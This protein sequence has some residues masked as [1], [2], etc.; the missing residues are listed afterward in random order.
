M[1]YPGEGVTDCLS[2]GYPKG[3]MEW[4][5]EPSMTGFLARQGSCRSLH[6]L[7]S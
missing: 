4:E 1:V 3:S 5:M 2:F 6:P 7:L